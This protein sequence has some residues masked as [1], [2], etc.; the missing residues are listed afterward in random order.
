MNK[1]KEATG[2]NYNMAK[3]HSSDKYDFYASSTIG[4]N[5]ALYNIVS[6]GSSA[7]KGGYH[8]MRYIENIRGERFPD[9]YQPTKHGT[10]SLYPH[11]MEPSKNESIYD[12]YKN[13]SKA[14]AKVGDVVVDVNTNEHKEGKITDINYGYPE[15]LDAK[16]KPDEQFLQEKFGLDIARKMWWV[17]V[18]G[19]EAMPYGDDGVMSMIMIMMMIKVMIYYMM[20]LLTIVTIM[21]YDYADDYG[22][23]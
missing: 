18:D 22:D 8:N 17:A 19:D 12:G 7:P 2:T 15:K 5:Q 9:R 3:L 20:L 11:D 6:R 21:M 14:P 1:I 13:P 23:G 10:N 16:N 4:N